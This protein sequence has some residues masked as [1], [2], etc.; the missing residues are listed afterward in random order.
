MDDKLT[1]RSLAGAPVELVM[2][3]YK[4][5]VFAH[6][7]ILR[8]PCGFFDAALNK[9]W[10]EGQKRV[11]HMPDDRADAVYAYVQW[12]Y[13]GRI[14]AKTRDADGDP[15]FNPFA[16]LY[17]LGEKLLDDAFQDR[18][19]SALAVQG[20]KQMPS[21]ESIEIIY[22]GTAEASP[23]RRW[24]VDSWV[25]KAGNK[26]VEKC[27]EKGFPLPPEFQRDLIEAF[28]RRH[29]MRAVERLQA[30]RLLETRMMCAYHKHGAE[31]PCTVKE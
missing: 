29:P 28:V 21:F 3:E 6:E 8:K 2:G 9:K 20:E 22:E 16:R 27:K 14:F 18:V 11:I 31:M 10:K 24:L 19:L 5:S 25:Q 26:T 15:V 17:V 4:A 23:A 1:L 7:G 13:T 12:L 30:A